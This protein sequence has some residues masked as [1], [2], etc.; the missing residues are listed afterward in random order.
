MEFTEDFDKKFPTKSLMMGR[1]PRNGEEL[2]PVSIKLFNINNP[3]NTEEFPVEE[4]VCKN[5]LYVKIHKL[6]V[7]YYP[8]GNDIIINDLEELRVTKKGEVLI[9]RGYHVDKE[10]QV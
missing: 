4:L 6:N 3:Q 7:T 8:E 5:I 2:K 1:L 10:L 9:L